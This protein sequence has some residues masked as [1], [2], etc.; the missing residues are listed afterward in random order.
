MQGEVGLLNVITVPPGAGLGQRIVIDGMRGAIFEYSSSNQLVGSWASSAGT[1]PYGNAYPA[2]FQVQGVIE[3][4]AYILNSAGFF[5]YS[6]TPANGNLI[7]A[8]TSASGTDQF[9]N[10]YPAGFFM[11]G[12]GISGAYFRVD[13][14]GV[15]YFFNAAGNNII[16]INPTKQALYIYNSS[17][18]ALGNLITSLASVAG[19]DPFGNPVVEGLQIN[20]GLELFYSGAPALG[21]LIASIAPAAGTDALGNTYLQGITSYT[22]SGGTFLAANFSFGELTFQSANSAGGSY[23]QQANIQSDASGDV[24]FFPTGNVFINSNLSVIAA[25]SGTQNALLVVNSTIN[26]GQPSVQVISGGAGDRAI[27]IMVNGDTAN[28]VLL[29]TAALKT[30]PGNAVQDTQLYR[31]AAGQWGIDQILQNVSGN[32]EVWHSLGTLAGATVNKGRYR[33]LPDGEVKV[34]ID[35]T[36]AVST[37]VPIT[38]SNTL[39]AAYQPPGSVDVRSPYAQANSAGGLCRAFVGSASGANPGQVMIA[40]FS[41]AIGTY[42]AYF[43]YSIL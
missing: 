16:R 5:L 4:S 29:T 8:W 7:G 22:N 13:Q 36:F 28:R 10:A 32:A 18:G 31:N 21:N 26:P 6:S 34:E 41:N 27:G 25:T 15:A 23:T 43:S 42:S 35:I 2:G 19:T 33:F 38:F 39:P 20:Q 37:A 30:G 11:G 9:G 3:G 24:S 12:S 14:N 40:G 1:D 17:G